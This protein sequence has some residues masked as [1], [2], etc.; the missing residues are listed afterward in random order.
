MWHS[1]LHIHKLT[2]T[3]PLTCYYNFIIFLK[4]LQIILFLLMFPYKNVQYFTNIIK[5]KNFYIALVIAALVA[6]NNMKVKLF[7]I[8]ELFYCYTLDTLQ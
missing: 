1:I 7:V 3:L 5:H 8:I 2:A 6:Y 4:N